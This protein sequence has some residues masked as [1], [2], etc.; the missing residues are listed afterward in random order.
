MASTRKFFLG[1]V[2]VHASCL[3]VD[4]NFVAILDKSDRSAFLCLGDDVAWIKTHKMLVVGV[5]S[6]RFLAKM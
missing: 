3:G 1:D 4:D 2:D 6:W 5:A